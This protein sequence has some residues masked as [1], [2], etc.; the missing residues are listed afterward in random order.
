MK[1]NDFKKIIQENNIH[2]TFLNEEGIVAA[3]QQSYSLGVKDV[4]DWLKNM[5]HISDNVQYLVEE[6][7]NQHK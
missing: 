1:Q 5:N 6:W 3:L 4:L 2:S 7:N